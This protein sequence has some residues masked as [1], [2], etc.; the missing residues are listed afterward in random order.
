MKKSSTWDT[1]FA[2]STPQDIQHSRANTDSHNS[3]NMQ[4]ATRESKKSTFC[5]M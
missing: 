1:A 4:H 3:H 2:P 5:V